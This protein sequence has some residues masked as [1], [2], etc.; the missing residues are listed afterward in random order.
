MQV[1]KKKEKFRCTLIT[2]SIKREITLFYVAV[3]Q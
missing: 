3:M 2:F 1:Q